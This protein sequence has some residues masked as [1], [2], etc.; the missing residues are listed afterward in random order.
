MPGIQCEGLGL[1]HLSYHRL[2]WVPPAGHSAPPSRPQPLSPLQGLPPSS[3]RLGKALSASCGLM[4]GYQQALLEGQL[5]HICPRPAPEG[6]APW[7]KPQ[8]MTTTAQP[9]S[10]VQASHSV[11]EEE[12]T[13]EEG[14]V[15]IHCPVI[16]GHKPTTKQQQIG[17]HMCQT[18]HTHVT[19]AWGGASQ[20]QS[21]FRVRVW[22]FSLGAFLCFS[23]FL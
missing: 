11:P 5:G 21:G 12:A 8:R 6:S 10:T 4:C 23:H 16:T 18:E 9:R 15:V 7:E 13:Q 17:A 2:L 20:R 1:P 19:E 3:T 14:R 22:G